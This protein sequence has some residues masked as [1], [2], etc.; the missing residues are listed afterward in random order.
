MD[1]N[2]NQN[3]QR[4][5]K[6]IAQSGLCSRRAA[7]ALIRAG[8]VTCNGAVVRDLSTRADRDT[9]T[10]AVD[11]TPLKQEKLLYLM[12][13]KPAGYVTTVKDPHAKKTVY[14]LLPKLPARVFPVG[15][16]DKDTAGLLLLTNDGEFAFQLT[17]PRF[18]VERVYL[19]EAAGKVGDALIRQLEK[20]G[21]RIDGYST[22][23]CAI[24]LLA[25]NQIRTRMKITLREGRKRQIRIMLSHIGHP[26]MR[27]K[28]VQYGK[29]TLGTLETG[30]WQYVRKQDII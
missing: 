23:P 2:K 10:I 20:G 16:L 7:D 24:E 11:G 4:L 14:D 28:R 25:R 18:G 22:T 5:N 12:L 21:M 6:L 13:N 17:H 19:A 29:L 8:K 3:S 30:H 9:D 26:V 1:M 15:R 27:L